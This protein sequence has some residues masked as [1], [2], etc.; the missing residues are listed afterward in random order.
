MQGLQKLN[1]RVAVVD[2][3]CLEGI[4]R[5]LRL[6]RMCKDRFTPG[7][8]FAVMEIVRLLGSTP[9]LSRQEL[10]CEDLETVES[11]AGLVFMTDYRH[12]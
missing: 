2:T 9:K 3:Q 6:A 11:R 1:N 5:P 10:L 7:G 12:G 4:A 8:K